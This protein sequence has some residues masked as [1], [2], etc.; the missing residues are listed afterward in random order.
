MA[1]SSVSRRFAMES[2]LAA[3]TNLELMCPRNLKDSARGFD[4]PAREF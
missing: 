2:E 3:L 1:A 4:I